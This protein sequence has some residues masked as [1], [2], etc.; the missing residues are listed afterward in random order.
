MTKGAFWKLKDLLKGNVN[1]TTRKRLLNCYV[2]SVL[3]Y[4][5]ETWTMYES[6]KKRS[7]AFEYWCY[8]RMLKISWKDKVSNNEVLKRI[9]EKELEFYKKMT[10]QKLSYAG[11]VLRGSCGRN[12]LVIIEGKIKGKK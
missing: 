8:W 7:N 5:C 1:M 6:L 9:G 11:H 10:Q 12:A 4:G 3:K 2:F